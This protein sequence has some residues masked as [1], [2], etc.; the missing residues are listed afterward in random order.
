MPRICRNRRS[1]YGRKI[2]D[3]VFNKLIQQKFMM[4]KSIHDVNNNTNTG[5]IFILRRYKIEQ[6][7][8][9][10]KENCYIAKAFHG[11][12][13]LV[14]MPLKKTKIILSRSKLNFP[15]KDIFIRDF[16][17]TGAGT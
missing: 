11:I 1:Q 13:P 9:I 7:K 3:Q 17:P 10:V 12:Q 14:N 4:K 6:E 15:N 5:G 8:E 2:Y 16:V